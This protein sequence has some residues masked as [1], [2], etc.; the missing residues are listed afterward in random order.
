MSATHPESATLVHISLP[1]MLGWG[2]MSRVAHCP[3]VNSPHVLKTWLA[4]FNTVLWS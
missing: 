4:M 2:L 1:P 3:V